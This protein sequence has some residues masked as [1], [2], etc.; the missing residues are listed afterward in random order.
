MRNLICLFVLASL[1]LLTACASTP[2]LTVSYKAVEV[3]AA[4]K[5]IDPIAEDIKAEPNPPNL[6]SAG[7]YGT[8]DIR[9]QKLGLYALALRKWGRDL[10]TA[11]ESREQ[12]QA[13]MRERQ[14]AERDAALAKIAQLN[15]EE[16]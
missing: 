9:A 3:V 8:S 4:P 16:N 15:K 6:P 11:I 7:T 10:V 2:K 12:A 14:Q 13:K 1:S 5:P